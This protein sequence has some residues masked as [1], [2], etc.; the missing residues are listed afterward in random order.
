MGGEVESSTGREQSM[1]EQQNR[2]EAIFGWRRRSERSGRCFMVEG[3]RPRA[4]N[5]SCAGGGGRPDTGGR[6]TRRSP[7]TP[8]ATRAP[9]PVDPA[10]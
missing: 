10:D 3:R 4:L 8:Q 2:L 6:A 1:E 9:A 7:E 5:T